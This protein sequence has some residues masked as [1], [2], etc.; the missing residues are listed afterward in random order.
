MNGAVSHRND[1]AYKNNWKKVLLPRHICVVTA[2]DD[3]FYKLVRVELVNHAISYG[4]NIS[5]RHSL[6]KG[7]S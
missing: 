7:Q 5:R 1:T 3:K 4:L 2:K 6:K